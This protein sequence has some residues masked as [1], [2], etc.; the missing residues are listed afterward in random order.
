VVAVTPCS[1][2]SQASSR[3]LDDEREAWF[4]PEEVGRYVGLT[5]CEKSSSDATVAMEADKRQEIAANCY[6]VLAIADFA[7]VFGW[8]CRRVLFF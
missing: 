1:A 3:S 7:S 2:F 6:S 4:L 8:V 5:I